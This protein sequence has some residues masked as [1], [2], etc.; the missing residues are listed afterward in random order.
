MTGVSSCEAR[1]P[2]HTFPNYLVSLGVRNIQTFLSEIKL[3]SAINCI[4]V[5]GVALFNDEVTTQDSL[6]SIN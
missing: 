1:T 3:G 4:D 6:L 5:E 2:T